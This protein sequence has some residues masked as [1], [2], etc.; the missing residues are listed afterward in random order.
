LDG[1]DFRILEPKPFSPKWYSHKFRSAGLRYEVGICIR[2][3]KIV[4]QNGGY[5]CGAYP[6]LKLAQQAYINIVNDGELTMADKGY[7]DRKY[8]ILPNPSNSIRH[9][10]I[11]SRHETVNKRLRH[12]KVLYVPFRHSI[13]KHIIC[14]NAV[15][16]ITELTIEN[17]EPLFSII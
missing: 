3:G 17:G 9:K 11:M 2:T 1:V 13:E 16:N 10:Q 5:P 6:D 8:F 12:F 14:F 4:W 7:R 15:V